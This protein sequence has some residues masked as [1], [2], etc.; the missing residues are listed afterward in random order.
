MH[1]SHSKLSTPFI[2]PHRRQRHGSSLREQSFLGNIT[3]SERSQ[4]QKAVYYMTHF[5]EIPGTEPRLVVAS[6]SGG[7]RMEGKEGEALGVLFEAM[8]M[9]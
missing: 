2:V 8:N 5:C 9:F 4:S 1:F 7:R 3:P 6:A